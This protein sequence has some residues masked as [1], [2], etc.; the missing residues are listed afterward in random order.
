GYVNAH[1]T[2]T[3][4]NDAAEGRAIRAALGEDAG[5]CP[6]TSIKGAIGH[7]LAASGAIEAIAAIGT[8]RGGMIPP[9]A[10]LAEPDPQLD[11]DLVRGAP[12]AADCRVVLSNSFGFGGANT[13]LCLRRWEA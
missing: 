7:T 6:V 9:T 2:G 12:R 8:L 4:A 11:L 5:N 13:V 1:G 10:G 3:P